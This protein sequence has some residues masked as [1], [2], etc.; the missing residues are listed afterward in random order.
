MAEIDSPALALQAAVIAAAGDSADVT[1]LIGDPARIY[2]RVPA[3][4]AFPYVSFGAHQ[5]IDDSFECHEGTEIWFEMDIWDQEA[6][7]NVRIG[8]ILQAMKGLVTEAALTVNGHK[9]GVL[10]FRD[11]IYLR[12]PDG[13]S[14]RVRATWR[15]LTEE[16]GDAA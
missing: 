7:G 4:A 13:I 6:H 1:A 9:L 11:A 16:S 2:D 5:E 3:D 14:R 8:R 12:D 15:V 10:K